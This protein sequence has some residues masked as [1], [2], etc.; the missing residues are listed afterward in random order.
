MVEMQTSKG[1][2]EEEMNSLNLKWLESEQKI[3]RM[4]FLTEEAERGKETLEKSL[5]LEMA[6]KDMQHRSAIDELTKKCADA[7]AAMTAAQEELRTAKDQH[8]EELL[9]THE[10]HQQ[11]LTRLQEEWKQREEQIEANC[12]R[13]VE[14]QKQAGGST[15]WLTMARPCSRS[16]TD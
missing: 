2:V 13:E 8:A 9:K 5:K 12:S 15:I 4:C 11:L 16:Q 3:A 6:T 1:V 14:K 7:T 10:D